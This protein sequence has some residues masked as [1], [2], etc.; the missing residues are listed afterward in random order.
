MGLT[1]TGRQ[2]EVYCTIS[3]I[4]LV[5]LVTKFYSPFLLSERWVSRQIFSANATT[6]V[7]TF[8]IA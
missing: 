5:G 2:I 1:L 6:K 3:K 8:N 4:L 7:V